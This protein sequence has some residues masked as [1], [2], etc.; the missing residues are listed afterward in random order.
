MLQVMSWYIQDLRYPGKD[1]SWHRPFWEE[2]RKWES[3]CMARSSAGLTH[4]EHA[5]R[6]TPT[7]VKLRAA[8]KI[9]FLF[10]AVVLSNFSRHKIPSLEILIQ[11]TRD[12]AQGDSCFLKRYCI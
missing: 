4:S 7:L 10:R 12:R 2:Q 9:S 11:Q 1:Q 3:V 8:R 6:P 5:Q